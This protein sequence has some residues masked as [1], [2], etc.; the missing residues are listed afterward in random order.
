MTDTRREHPPMAADA[1]SSWLRDS[2]DPDL[3]DGAFTR[4]VM[5]RIPAPGAR[6][7]RG[8]SLRARLVRTLAILAAAAVVL[9]LTPAGAVLIDRLGRLGALGPALVATAAP[10]WAA[11]ARGS[12]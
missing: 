10:T 4:T 5:R 1:L 2:S 3:D 7:L 6:P 11:A 12:D 9:A 8:R